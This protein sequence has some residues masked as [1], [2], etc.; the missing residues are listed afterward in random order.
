LSF[1]GQA[2]SIH[3]VDPSGPVVDALLNKLKASYIAKNNISIIQCYGQDLTIPLP[4]NLIFIA[5]MGGEEIGEIVA[6]L[7]PQLDSS[8]RIVISP[9]RK[10]L[11]LRRL[12]NQLPLSL[13]EEKVLL[14]DD[15]FYQFLCLSPVETGIKVSLYGEEL[16]SS[17]V[18]RSYLGHQ[19]KHF[20]SHQDLAS[21][22]YVSFLK[23][24]NSLK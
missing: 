22:G 21:Q 13:I 15:Q 1:A 7:L 12:L 20:S 14:E 24:L 6:K 17:E 18:G 3:L 4:S 8:S 16:W 19:I 2:D 5:G 10:I 23:D 9:H 11:E